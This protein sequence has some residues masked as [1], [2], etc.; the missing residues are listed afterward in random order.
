MIGA[1][2]ACLES[3]REVTARTGEPLGPLLDAAM[4]AFV[5]LTDVY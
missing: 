2:V 5:P 1:A 3:A 4:N